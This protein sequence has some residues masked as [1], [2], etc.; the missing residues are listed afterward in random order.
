MPRQNA[1]AK[2][3][4]SLAIMAPIMGFWSC[5]ILNYLEQHWQYFDGFKL[6]ALVSLQPKVTPRT[7]DI[8]PS[9]D[10]PPLPPQS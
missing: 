1:R 2:S 10:G 7:L 5:G 9:P 6:S 3:L 4:D 8:H